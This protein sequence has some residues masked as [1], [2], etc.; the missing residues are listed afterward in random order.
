MREIR[1]VFVIKD[2][3]NVGLMDYYVL[4]Q[5]HIKEARRADLE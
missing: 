4:L 2:G 5:S 3:D 1:S